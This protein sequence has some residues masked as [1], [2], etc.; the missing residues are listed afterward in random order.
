MYKYDERTGDMYR[1]LNPRFNKP[2]KEH[3]SWLDIKRTGT[4]GQR[5]TIRAGARGRECSFATDGHMTIQDIID[6]IV[7]GL[8]L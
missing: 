2:I 6:T 8:R 5:M 1:H 4:D 7:K 3:I